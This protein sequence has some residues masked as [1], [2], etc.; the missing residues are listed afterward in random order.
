MKLRDY[1]QG[2]V[3]GIRQALTEARSTLVVSPTGTG[4]TVVMGGAIKEFGWRA[5]VIAHREELIFQ[6]RDTIQTMLGPE[7]EVAVEMG[8]FRAVAG[9][10][11]LGTPTVVVATVQSLHERR[12][13]RFSPYWFDAL[14]VDEAHHGVR[15]NKT[16]R[17][18]LD[19]FGENPTLKTVGFTATPD[20][21]DEVALGEV[22][23]TVAAEYQICDAVGDGWLVPIEQQMVHV[24]DL[25]LSQVQT[26]MGDLA[27]G[28]L[29]SLL[30]EEKTCH[31]IVAPS[32]EIAGDRKTLTFCAGV[33]QAYKVAEIFNR[34]KPGSAVAM[35]GKTPREQRRHTLA[36]FARGEFQHLVNCALFLEGFDE[37]G[38]ECIIQARPTKSRSL[39]AQV[40]G[41]GTRVLSGVVEGMRDG[42]H[43]R[44]ES[45]EERREAI[46]KSG[47]RELLV[48]DFVGNAGRH[49]LVYAADLLGG[50][51][52][53]EVIAKAKQIAEAAGKSG[54]SVDVDESLR[55]AQLQIEDE[56]AAKRAKIVAAAKYSVR[57]VDPFQVFDRP[58]GREPGWHK[59]R[60]ATE[61]QRAALEKFGVPVK[62][63]GG[64]WF[65]ADEKTKKDE[66]VQ[67]TFWKAKQILDEL[68]GR[69]DQKLATYK[70]CRLLAKFGERTDVTFTEASAIIDQIAKNGWK[71]REETVE[72]LAKE[73][74]GGETSIEQAWR[75]A[76]EKGERRRA[77]RGG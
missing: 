68:I 3:G 12:L 60:E 58:Y 32:I 15:S 23:K 74:E 9:T 36:A 17:R 35:D 62:R 14:I 47:K 25:D 18:V 19:Y 45:A 28:E 39:Y 44:L 55:Q 61:R 27:A 49:S 7:H 8:E 21:A 10:G 56:K 6:N 50:R 4:K 53:D 70:Q 76:H 1:Q 16:Y 51:S 72:R 59:G 5:L 42:K 75:R 73:S 37:P 77:R 22:F 67:L 57:P 34:H 20:R 30:S 26:R 31:Q 24:D 69:I 13:E 11:L 33:K 66:W 71:P 54:E 64:E 63:S 41:R 43:W 46:A 40:I 65:I 48:I 38:I 2:Q 52:S 29:D